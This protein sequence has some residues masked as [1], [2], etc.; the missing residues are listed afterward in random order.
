MSSLE[1]LQRD[2]LSAISTFKPYGYETAELSDAV[3]LVV[4]RIPR[5]EFIDRFVLAGY[6][7]KNV[8][9]AR[10][11]PDYY[12]LV[13]APQ[14]LIYI[15]PGRGRVWSSNSDPAFILHLVDLLGLESGHRVLEI[16][17]GTGYLLAVMA[18]LAD[19]GEVRG[20]EIE[21]ELVRQAKASLRNWASPMPRSN[22]ARCLRSR[23]MA[24]VSTV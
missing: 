3:R 18:G 6:Q 19:A 22:R 20:I 9:Y 14:P 5:H 11:H 1:S 2:F 8:I 15:L 4:A 10:D 13:Y 7:P 21:G 23:I 12:R 17:A 24:R 16:G